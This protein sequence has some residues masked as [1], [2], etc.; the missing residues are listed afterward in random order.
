MNNY[1]SRCLQHTEDSISITQ[2]MGL[3][4]TQRICTV[5]CSICGVVK[6]SGRINKQE[7]KEIEINNQQGENKQ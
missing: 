3:K 6:F 1:C 4:T 7:H 5:E 2:H